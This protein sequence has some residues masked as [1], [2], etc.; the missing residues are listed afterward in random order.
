ME[1]FFA[2]HGFDVVYPE[3]YDL[4]HQAVIFS[5]AEVIAGFGGSAMFNAMFNR[6]Q[7]TVILLSHEAYTARNE[8]LFSA[9]IGGHAALLL[10]HPGRP[11]P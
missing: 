1:A 11:S 7:P 3:L 6:N 9:L 8:H 5:A 2:E 10:E 4:A